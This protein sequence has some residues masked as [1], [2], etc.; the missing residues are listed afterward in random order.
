MS[1]NKHKKRCQKRLV[2]S[3]HLA[4]KHLREDRALSQKQAAN[5]L[6]L[7]A[8]SIGAIENGRVYLGRERIEQI[9][10]SYEF[11]Y[12][13]FVRAKKLIER[14]ELKKSKTPN[15]I[16]KVL[17]NSDRRSYQKII[18]K[19]CK[20]LRSLRR[21]NGISQDQASTLCGYSR[22][23]IGHIENGRIEL[24]KERVAHIL[25]CYGVTS[26]E[27]EECLKKETQRDELVDRCVEKIQS[28]GDEKLNFLKEMLESFQ[29]L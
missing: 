7:S 26:F 14:G 28:L 15:S 22:P 9:V 11:T 24:T 16:K 20:V 21:Q 6:G 1:K 8:K 19:A 25:E 27:F 5:G 17:S 12:L 3:V 13:D 4:L 18:T 29:K 2:S 23:S 10:N